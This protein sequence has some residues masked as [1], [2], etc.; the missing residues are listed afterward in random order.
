MNRR[1][2]RNYLSFILLILIF[3]LS[4]CT[5]SPDFELYEGKAL[6][7]AVVGEPPEVKGE[8]VRFTEISFD[9]MTSEELKSYDAVFIRENNLSEA[10]ESQYADVYLNSTIP[11]FFIGTDFYVPFTEKDLEYDKTS[12][13]SAGISYAVGVLGSQEDDTLK[14]WEYGLYNDEKT[15]EHIKGMYSIIFKTIDELNQ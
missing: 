6:K 1:K 4:A 9:E 11:F 15:D 12:N 10:A 14:K 5:Q 13:W 8:Q 3:A 7:I 2:G